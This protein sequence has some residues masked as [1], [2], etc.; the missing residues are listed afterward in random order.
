MESA[1]GQ[2]PFVAYECDGKH[3]GSRV[4]GQKII[5]GCVH[6]LVKRPEQPAVFVSGWSVQAWF[7]NEADLGKWIRE[8]Q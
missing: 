7:S 8:S 1:W 6:Y 5:G 4:I 3:I 2:T